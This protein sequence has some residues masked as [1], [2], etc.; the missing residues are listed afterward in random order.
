MCFDLS[1]LQ[2]PDG[3]VAAPLQGSESTLQFPALPLGDGG[4]IYS[5]PDTVQGH[6]ECFTDVSKAAMHHGCTYIREDA[7]FLSK[8]LGGLK[9]G[10]GGARQSG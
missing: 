3:G 1:S 2:L 9:A 10:G 4:V 6:T 7:D 8:A 5:L